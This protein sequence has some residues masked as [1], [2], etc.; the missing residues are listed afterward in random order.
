L[1]DLEKKWISAVCDTTETTYVF[2]TTLVRD[3]EELV[4]IQSPRPLLKRN[5]FFRPL[6][7]KNMCR[8]AYP[9]P[10]LSI[11]EPREK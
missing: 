8:A 10:N 7:K 5:V 2:F 9:G 3:Q 11:L 4:Q 6:K 1:K